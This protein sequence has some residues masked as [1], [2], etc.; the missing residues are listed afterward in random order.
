MPILNDDQVQQL[1]AESHTLATRA[2]ERWNALEEIA[3]AQERGKDAAYLGDLA[4]AAIRNLS[5]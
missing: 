3:A 5:R 2:Q 1:L 4:R